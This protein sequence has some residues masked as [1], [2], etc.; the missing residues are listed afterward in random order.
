MLG[1]KIMFLFLTAG[2]FLLISCHQNPYSRG[3]SLYESVC[4]SCHASNGLGL[5][6]LIPPIAGSDYWINNQDKLPCIIR[7]GMTSPVTVNGI[8][9][10]MQT[11]PANPDLGEGDIANIINFINHKWGNKE[12]YIA[13]EKANE[14]LLECK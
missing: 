12:I 6:N 11:M 7:H 3:E 2:F 4:A 9:Y 10:D 8:I 14:L 13:P 5:S 1:K